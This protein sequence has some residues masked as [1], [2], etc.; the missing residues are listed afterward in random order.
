MKQLSLKYTF[1]LIII[2]ITI[3]LI[4]F[5][6]EKNSIDPESEATMYNVGDEISNEHKD[7]EFDICYGDYPSEKFKLSDFQNKVIWLHFSATWWAPCFGFIQV[8]EAV[9]EYW[10]NNEN[11]AIID[12]LDYLNQPYTCAQWGSVGNPNLPTII[13]DKNYNFIDQFHDV[14]PTNVFIDHEMK[15]HAVL[16]TMYTEE[17]VNEKIQEMLD[18]MDSSRK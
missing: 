3:S 1:T 5:A 9:E 17:S 4:F 2:I 12:F 6:C 8:G 11:V 10:E 16:D 14:Y 18:K 15:V 13:D 7:I